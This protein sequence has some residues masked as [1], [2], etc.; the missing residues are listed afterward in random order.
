MNEI[1]RIQP[2]RDSIGDIRAI[3]TRVERREQPTDEKQR[4][5][6][7]PPEQGDDSFEHAKPK[8]NPGGYGPSG[9]LS[10]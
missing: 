10:S 2:V 9:Q 6:H 5:H 7:E 3:T 8:P 1:R 4:E